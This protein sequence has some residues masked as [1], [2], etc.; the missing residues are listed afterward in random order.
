M[1]DVEDSAPLAD[2]TQ[3]MTELAPDD[4]RFQDTLGWI[5]YRKGIYGTASNYLK[6]AVDARRRGIACVL[7][8]DPQLRAPI[9]LDIGAL[10]SGPR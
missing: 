7:S 6:A 2:I 8:R 5:Y 10:G 9:G 1:L 3:A 4:P